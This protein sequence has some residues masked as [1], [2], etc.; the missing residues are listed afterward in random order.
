MSNIKSLMFYLIQK[1]MLRTIV[2]LQFGLILTPPA[3]LAQQPKSNAVF[4]TDIDNFWKAYDSAVKTDNRESQVSIIQSL[5]IDI[6]TDGLKAFMSAR[7]YTAENYVRLINDYP[8][9]WKSVR[10]NTLAIKSQVNLI[11][12]SVDRL[13]LLY[14]AI[15]PAGI[16]F[17]IGGLKSGGTTT[18]N[19]VLI[20]AEMA[21]ADTGTDASE[22]SNWLR[23]VFS[24]QVSGNIV[25]L[26]IHE[27]VHTQ[28]KKKGS[29]LLAQC[30]QEGSADFIAE[31]VTRQKN[32]ND[33]MI[34]GQNNETSLKLRFRNEMWRRSISNWLYNGEKSEHPDLGYFMGYTICRAYYN[35]AADKQ[36]AV[37]DIIELDYT[38]KDSV[39]NFLDKSSYYN[40]PNLRTQ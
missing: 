26:N 19:M 27:Y 2:M 7:N 3:G 14:P 9:F 32:L 20:G 34:Y 1:M 15:K 31:L 12:K 22:L 16:Y 36:Q 18:E 39:T 4:T 17:T 29:S 37:K 5:Y 10:K 28:Q 35:R 30:L 40:N 23:T 25:G 13:K 24:S 33:Y 6:G 38:S 11:E 21:A 8:A